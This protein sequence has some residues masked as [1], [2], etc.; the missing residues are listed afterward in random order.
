MC[1][2]LRCPSE[3]ALGQACAPQRFARRRLPG[4]GCHRV[5]D[6]LAGLWHLALAISIHH[7]TS[8]RS[9]ETGFVP[10]GTDRLM[11][12]RTRKTPADE[13]DEPIFKLPT[14]QKRS[15]LRVS[16]ILFMAPNKVDCV[17]DVRQS[18]FRPPCPGN[19]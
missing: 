9:V 19:S 10:V 8:D 18:R 7:A 5:V 15:L 3:F 16:M 2:L 4:E 11:D 13:P 14:L 12:A 6:R 1:E 17:C